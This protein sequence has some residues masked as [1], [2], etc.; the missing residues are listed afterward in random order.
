MPELGVNT[1]GAVDGDGTAFDHAMHGA[2]NENLGADEAA[3]YR[4]GL[5]DGD[6]GRDDV[7]VKD[8]VNLNR[9][10]GTQG[11]GNLHIACDDGQF[12]RP[13]LGRA[14]LIGSVVTSTP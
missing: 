7:A 9:P 6:T 4:A 13:T 2:K 8:A 3:D 5:T 11:A 10:S 14:G 12:P 1:G